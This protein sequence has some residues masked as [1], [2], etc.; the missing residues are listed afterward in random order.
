ML[1]NGY[2]QILADV[3]CALLSLLS[4]LPLLFSSELTLKLMDMGLLLTQDRADTEG[5]S[6]PVS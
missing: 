5:T 3:K 1:L 2:H 6:K 4:P